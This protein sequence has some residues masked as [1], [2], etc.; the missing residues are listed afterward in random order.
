ME[1]LRSS[2]PSRLRCLAMLALLAARQSGAAE[3]DWAFN[4][5]IIEA[6][7][8][9]MF[10]QCYFNSRP[11][12]HAG[13]G[14]H[15]EQRFCRFNRAFE[16]NRGHFGSEELAGVR[17]WMAGDLGGDFSSN[18]MDWTVVTFEP[19][20]TKRQRTAIT[21]ILN[22]LYPVKWRSFAVG[23]DARMEWSATADRAEARL[24]GG[25]A[26]EV[27][28]HKAQGTT[29]DAIVIN[30][31]EYDGAP[32]ND[33]FRLMP[34]EVEAYRV[35]DRAFEFKGTTGFMITIDMTSADIRK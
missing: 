10:C 17:F 32:R 19:S 29:D 16:V 21:T 31:L 35:G 11:A 24:D 3:P 15:G 1:Q 2:L 12:A 18:V 6:C 27:V 33:G 14:E 5:T 13:H 23:T 28:L 9:P 22:H 30:N 34:N 8:C 7:S 26:A 20:T 4:A 25:R